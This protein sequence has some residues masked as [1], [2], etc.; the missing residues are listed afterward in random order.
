MG[1]AARDDSTVSRA[2]SSQPIIQGHQD[3]LKRNGFA[4]TL[5]HYEVL[6][7]A[8]DCAF[9]GAALRGTMAVHQVRG[10]R[11]PGRSS[12]Q[13]QSWSKLPLCTCCL[14]GKA[15]ELGQQLRLLRQNKATGDTRDGRGR[16]MDWTH[17][18]S[19]Q[20]RRGAN[21]H[22]CPKRLAAGEGWTSSIMGSAIRSGYAYC[23]ERITLCTPCIL[24]FEERNLRF[25]RAKRCKHGCQGQDGYRRLHERQDGQNW[26]IHVGYD[27]VHSADFC[28]DGASAHRLGVCQPAYSVE[29]AVI[30]EAGRTRA[31]LIDWRCLDAG[32]SKRMHHL[33]DTKGSILA[34]AAARHTWDTSG[35]FTRTAQQAALVA[36]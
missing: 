27:E 12:A 20:R 16:P 26:R 21:C 5:G 9:C 36:A 23:R 32:Q 22:G 19:N 11:T 35:Q 13:R 17:R 8:H 29:F 15:R 3:F 1:P 7:A 10:G 33:A 6:R 34:D 2:S 18:S 30:H 25:L 28:I 24:A 14:S 4:V 31:R